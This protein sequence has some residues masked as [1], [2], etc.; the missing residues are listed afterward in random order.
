MP[1][2]FKQ[3][4]YTFR[5]TFCQCKI[6]QGSLYLY[7]HGFGSWNY[8]KNCTVKKSKYGYDQSDFNHFRPEANYGYYDFKDSHDQEWDQ[9]R[10]LRELYKI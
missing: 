7:T 8:C 6:I 3:A 1:V 9:I 10:T 2:E 5:C 4:K